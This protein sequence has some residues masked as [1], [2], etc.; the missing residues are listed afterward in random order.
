[1]F[2]QQF[3]QIT[4]KEI[5]KVRVTV[6]LRGESTVIG[7]SPY[8]RRVE[9]VSIWWRHNEYHDGTYIISRNIHITL[10]PLTK[11]CS[12]EVGMSAS[13]WFPCYRW[14]RFL[15]TITP[16]EQRDYHLAECGRWA[17]KVTMGWPE[18]FAGKNV[19]VFTRFK[20]NMLRPLGWRVDGAHQLQS[21]KNYPL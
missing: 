10:Q 15:R 7:G 18:S 17:P 16:S 13:R 9:N 1:M 4:N 8:K 5:S 21:K 14:V 12:R 20:P 19:E 11:Q 6:P 3:V 2:V